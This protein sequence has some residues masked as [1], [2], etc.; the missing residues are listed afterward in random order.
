MLGMIKGDDPVEMLKAVN[1]TTL[2]FLD[3][4]N[5]MSKDKDKDMN[6]VMGNANPYI[7]PI[8]NFLTSKHK[9]DDY[10]DEFFEYERN[11][12]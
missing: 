6:V 12:K 2:A 9:L 4:C 1:A 10:E 11:E 7:T 5:D 3:I 8:Q